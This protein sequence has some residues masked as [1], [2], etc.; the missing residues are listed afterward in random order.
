MIFWR[1]CAI[2]IFASFASNIRV[3][4][5]GVCDP[6]LIVSADGVCHPELAREWF[7]EFLREE[8][9]DDAALECPDRGPR[10]AAPRLWDRSNPRKA[11]LPPRLG[12]QVPDL[13]SLIVDGK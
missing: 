6:D 1:P 5:S 12:V 4:V 9:S 11:R 3:E 8:C 7:R 10:K 2:L 13:P